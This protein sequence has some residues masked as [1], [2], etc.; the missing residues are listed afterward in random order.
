[1]NSELD[2]IILAELDRLYRFAYNRTHDT[3][4]SEDI[5]QNI[6]LNAYRAF[7]RLHDKSKLV[8]WLWGIARNTVMQ[9]YK[10]TVEIPTDEIVIHDIAGISYET[11]ES[12]YL[13]KSDIVNIRRAVSYLAKNYRD[14]CV[15]FY[16]ESK[17]YKTIAEELG[18]PLS[19]V[20]WRLNQSKIQ[21]REEI[22][23]MECMEQGYRKAI[24][25]KFN[26]GG[27]VNKWDR[28]LGNYDNADKALE[29]LLPQNICLGAYL[30]PKTVME[31][32]SDL[33]VAADYVEEALKKLV[34]TQCVKQTA[35]KYQPMFP[36]WDKAANSDVFNGNLDFA[37]SHAKEI[38]DIIFNLADD[39]KNIAFCGSEKG[40]EKLI[41]FLIGYICI[42]TKH[43][44][45]EVDK[46]PF[47]GID[48]AWYIL[49]TTESVF[50]NEFGYG[51][52]SSGSMFGLREYYFLQQFVKDNR[53]ENTEEQKAFYN[54]YL[55]ESVTDDYLLARLLESGK[56]LNNDVSYEI[57]VPVISN[58]RGEVNKLNSVL[59]PVFSITNDL[60]SKI[61]ERSCDTVKKYIPKH[62][63]N[64]TEFF[65]SY[66]SHS[67]L[68]NAL[69]KE[70]LLRNIEITPDMVTWFVVK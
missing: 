23:K 3:Y 64:Q 43:N 1:M 18:I 35:N 22:K 56:V 52:N 11:P 59:A 62:I 28:T 29:G 7:T 63:A 5:T 16:L 69:F 21:L 6:V 26:M 15:M 39:V 48:K 50:N 54:I 2:A 70:L 65:G 25:L 68:E 45:F 10:Q 49:G 42:N 44:K 36:I 9:S 33:G 17:D 27:Y 30:T 14:V 38:V 32:S 13:L 31:L 12:E 57:T 19:S 20:K 34:D 47:Q 55:G 66:C 67:V 46:L 4:R 51:I 53:F 61:Y 60:Q 58:E 24:P 37:K 8:P 40:I 41:M